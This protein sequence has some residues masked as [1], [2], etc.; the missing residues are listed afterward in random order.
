MKMDLPIILIW[1]HFINDLHNYKNLTTPA[2]YLN[3]ILNSITPKNS[4]TQKKKG[5]KS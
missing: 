4:K 3:I 5:K 1:L 2:K